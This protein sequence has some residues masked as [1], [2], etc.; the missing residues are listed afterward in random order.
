MDSYRARDLAYEE[1]T[2]W[3]LTQIG[4]RFAFNRRRCGLG[5]CSYS[6]KTI[7]LSAIYVNHNTESDVLNTIRHEI[8]HA[9]T[10]G[11]NHGRM[12]KLMA[13]KVGCVSVNRVNEKAN[14]PKGRWTIKC[15]L[16]GSTSEKHRHTKLIQTNA[17][18]YHCSKC[19]RRSVNM[20]EI[21]QNF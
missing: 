18:G 2:K 20:L 1:M 15:K 8:A 14:M 7:Y 13:M 4:W 12:W 11:A 10:P 21:I 16:C 6:N 5:L 17:K 9:L 19:G 3:G